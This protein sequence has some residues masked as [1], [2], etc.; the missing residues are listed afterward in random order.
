MAH[1]LAGIDLGSRFGKVTIIS[2][3]KVIARASSPV[4]DEVGR[5]GKRLLKM[6]L[7]EAGLRRRALAAVGVTG[8]GR[9]GAGRLSRLA[10]PDVTCAAMGVHFLAPM[11]RAAVDVGGLMT[12]AAAVGKNGEALEYVENER[13]A[14]GSGRFLETAA[15]ALETPVSEIGRLSLTSASPLRLTSQCVVF[16]E[17]ELISHVNAGGE[18][19]DILAGLHR[20]VADRVATLVKK[21]G[22]KGPIALVGGVARNEG[23]MAYIEKALA[24]KPAHLGDDPIFVGA[25]G[26]ALLAGAKKAG[27]TRVAD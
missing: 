27:R 5:L 22:A 19:A 2:D 26:A 10:F 23:V 16:A 17:S 7:A 21:L 20:S 15:E 14:A 3:G 24:E 9:H 4:D 1:I 8:H 11:A 6:A 13:C 25:M 12:R 18:A